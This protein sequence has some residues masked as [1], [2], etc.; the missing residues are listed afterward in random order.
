MHLCIPMA[1]RGSRFK[2]AGFNISK[3]FIDVNGEPMI[4]MVLRNLT[5]HRITDITL[6]CLSV[7]LEPLISA[8]APYQRKFNLNIVPI[9]KVTSGAAETVIAA[10]AFIEDSPLLIANCDQFINSSL[11]DFFC[12]IPDNVDGHIQCMTANSDKWSYIRYADGL[13]VEVAEKEVISDLATTGLYWF[14]NGRLC[15]KYIREM[16]SSGLTSKNEYYVAPVYNLMIRDG[17]EISYHSIG[18]DAN[19]MFGTGTPDDLAHFLN[20][21]ENIQYYESPSNRPDQPPCS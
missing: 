17:L 20:C 8:T 13:V 4:N 1:G 3:P 14:K 19:T 18:S 5:S 7:D 11:D 16:I 12:Q 21:L 6:I 15:L 10:D 2:K 9:P